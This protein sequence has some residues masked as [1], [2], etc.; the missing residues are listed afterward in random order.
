MYKLLIAI[1]IV[2]IYGCSKPQ[3]KDCAHP[4]PTADSTVKE[5]G[6]TAD[7]DKRKTIKLEESKGPKKDVIAPMI[8]SKPDGSD[9][10]TSGHRNDM[11][12]TEDA[13]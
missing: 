10:E 7:T 8:P 11:E 12:G 13:D 4:R 3:P 2:G 9:K 6:T 5:R 1:V